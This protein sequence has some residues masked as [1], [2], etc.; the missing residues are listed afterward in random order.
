[1]MLKKAKN[2]SFNCNNTIVKQAYDNMIKNYENTIM[3]LESN[4]KS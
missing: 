1:M 2:D 4:R 3:F